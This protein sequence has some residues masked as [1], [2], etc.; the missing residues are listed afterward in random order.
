MHFLDSFSPIVISFLLDSA[1]HMLTVCELERNNKLGQ[2]VTQLISH[3][4]I[5]C[6]ANK[7]LLVHKTLP[8]CYSTLMVI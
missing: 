5:Q 4:Q 2:G 7:N 1:F 3:L 8:P 6:H